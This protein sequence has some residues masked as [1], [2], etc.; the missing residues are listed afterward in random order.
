MLS[1][2]GISNWLIEMY[3]AEHLPLTTGLQ[4]DAM[5]MQR[6]QLGVLMSAPPLANNTFCNLI[7]FLLLCVTTLWSLFCLHRLRG[8]FYIYKPSV[9]LQLTF[10]FHTGE[11]TYE[12]LIVHFYYY[13]YYYYYDYYYYYY[14]E[15]TS[16]SDRDLLENWQWMKTMR[17][18]F[19]YSK[20]IFAISLYLKQFG[21]WLSCDPVWI[22]QVIITVPLSIQGSPLEL[23]VVGRFPSCM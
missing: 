11:V 16:F 3:F 21:L 18:P 10:T 9:F 22:I 19:M 15:S 20:M 13:Y 14:P 8:T 2:I 1:L 23:M 5:P 6:V 17:L 12:L 7:I 4:R